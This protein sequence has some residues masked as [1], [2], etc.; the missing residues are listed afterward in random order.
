MLPMKRRTK[1]LLGILAAG[2]A[3]LP[4]ALFGREGIALVVGVTVFALLLRNLRGGLH[5]GSDASY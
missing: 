2:A 4:I 3:V 1:M 5:G